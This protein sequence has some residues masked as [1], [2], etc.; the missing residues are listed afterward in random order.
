MCLL[1]VGLN[2]S[3]LN[4]KYLAILF[5]PFFAI[6]Q[7]SLFHQDLANT[8]IATKDA[9]NTIGLEINELMYKKILRDSPESFRLKLPFFNQHIIFDLKLFNIYNTLNSWE[10]SSNLKTR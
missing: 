10:Q 5:I 7:N 6:S 3:A 9:D 8:I 1:G 2:S 4:L